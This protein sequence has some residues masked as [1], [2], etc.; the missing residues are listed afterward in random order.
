MTRGR[1]VGRF[2]PGEILS[3]DFATFETLPIFLIISET[4]EVTHIF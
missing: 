2:F 3:P 1:G 4:K